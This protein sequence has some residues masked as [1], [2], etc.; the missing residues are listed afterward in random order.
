MRDAVGL[1]V[2][3]LLVWPLVMAIV[4]ALDALALADGFIGRTFVLS[5]VLVPTIK[6]FVGPTA[7]ALTGRLMRVR[8][9]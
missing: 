5:A 4:L 6:L 9:R 3:W 2:L 8:L 7:S 1:F